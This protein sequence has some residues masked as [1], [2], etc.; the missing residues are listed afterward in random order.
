M[1]CVGGGEI[2]DGYSKKCH[3]SLDG[4]LDFDLSNNL[5]VFF[6]NR[7]NIHNFSQELAV[8]KNADL[9]Q[10]SVNVDKDMVLKVF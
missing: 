7:F 3:I 9:E 4:K 5:N 1:S 6:Y 8:F 2:H 10:N